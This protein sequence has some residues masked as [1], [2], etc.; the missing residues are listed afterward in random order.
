M[1]SEASTNC[2]EHRRDSSSFKVSI[3]M[4]ILCSYPHSSP[5]APSVMARFPSVL[6][7]A[8]KEAGLPFDAYIDIERKFLLVLL[9]K[10]LEFI[11]LMDKSSG[12]SYQGAKEKMI[13]AV[14]D[15]IK[16]SLKEKNKHYDDLFAHILASNLVESFLE[17]MRHYKSQEWAT[18]MLDLLAQHFFLGSNS[19]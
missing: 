8:E 5:I 10:R 11:I 16:S 15:H 7:K 19:L 12:T 4:P 17:I 14:E 2:T 1:R 9:D 3:C 13:H 6:K 18:H